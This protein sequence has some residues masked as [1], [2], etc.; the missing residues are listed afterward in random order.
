[1]VL[2]GWNVTE[3]LEIA[4][5]F[6]TFVRAYRD[7][8]DQIKTFASQVNS[9]CAT[10][11]DLDQCLNNPDATPLEDNDP[12]KLASD[13]CRLCAENCQTFLE[14]FFKQ[15]DPP[16]PNVKAREEVGRRLQWMWR[17]DEATILVAEMSRQ[18][19]YIGLHLNIAER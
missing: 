2:P 5:K 3:P 4:V 18:I 15:F 9:F 12:L 6:Y 16:Q 10:L 17:K 1:M 19:S 13:G 8:N 14:N 11:R 7:A